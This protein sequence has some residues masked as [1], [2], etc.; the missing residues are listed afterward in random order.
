MGT[1]QVRWHGRSPGARRRSE[2]ERAPGE[3]M[4]RRAQERAAACRACRAWMN[5]RTE[6]AT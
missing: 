4:P 2:T 1:A 5:E 3:G 6:K